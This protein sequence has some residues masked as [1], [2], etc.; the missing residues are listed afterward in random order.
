MSAADTAMANHSGGNGNGN[1]SNG[2]NIN[3]SSVQQQQQRQPWMFAESF[4]SNLRVMERAVVQNY[5]EKVQLAYR[6][7]EMSEACDRAA[8]S[9]SSNK[10]HDPHNKKDKSSK[11][12]NYS[13]GP[14]EH[15]E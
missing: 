5:M 12:L 9:A 14:Y 6:G 4:L 15:S 2:S 1:G 8:I 10:S 3:K 7:I 13:S 11:S